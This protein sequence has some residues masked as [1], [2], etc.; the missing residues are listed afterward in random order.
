MTIENNKNTNEVNMI[1]LVYLLFCALECDERFLNEIKMFELFVV[2]FLLISICWTENSI[3]KLFRNIFHSIRILN[4]EIKLLKHCI[5]MDQFIYFYMEK[6]KFQFSIALLSIANKMDL[7]EENRMR[8]IED[9]WT[10]LC[11]RTC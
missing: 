3:E 4:V 11:S 10:D 5:W 2:F 7:E 9:H 6:C 1:L 8:W